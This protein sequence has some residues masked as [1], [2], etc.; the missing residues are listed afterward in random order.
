MNFYGGEKYC[1]IQQGKKKKQ[2]PQAKEIKITSNSILPGKTT[3][4]AAAFQVIYE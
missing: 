3:Q 4:T 2:S 1:Y